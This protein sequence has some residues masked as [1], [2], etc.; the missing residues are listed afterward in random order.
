M[1]AM[2]DWY[3][4]KNGQQLGP[5]DWPAL[6]QL[7]DS[8]QLLPDDL[9]WQE[10]RARGAKASQQRGCSGA[11]PAPPLMPPSVGAP[12]SN[13][14]AAPGARAQGMPVGY[15]QGQPFG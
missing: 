13:Y 4:S 3:Y 11:A 7:A 12:S 14:G 1:D 6:K 8:G 5:I 10:G 15:P 2:A 9:V